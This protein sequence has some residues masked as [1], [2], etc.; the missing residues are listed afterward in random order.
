MNKIILKIPIS[1]QFPPKSMVME[2]SNLI[3]SPRHLEKY[4]TLTNK[5]VYDGIMT[6]DETTP[7]L[8]AIEQKLQS[9]EWDEIKEWFEQRLEDASTSSSTSL[10]LIETT[11]ALGSS[12]LSTSIRIIAICSVIKGLLL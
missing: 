2:L 6:R 10:R 12:A 4:K 11:A 8:T 9:P 3:N 5:L 7:L 1:T